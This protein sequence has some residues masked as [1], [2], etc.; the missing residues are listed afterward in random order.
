MATIVIETKVEEC[1][2]FEHTHKGINSLLKRVLL[3]SKYCPECGEYLKENRPVTTRKC[4]NCGKS[5][6]PLDLYQYKFCPNCGERL[7]H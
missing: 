7:E 4:S 6:L 5:L 3:A 1:H 2:K